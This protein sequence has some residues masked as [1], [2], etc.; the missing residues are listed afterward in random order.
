MRG[1]IPWLFFVICISGCT[2]PNNIGNDA[3]IHDSG[4]ITDSDTE[5]IQDSGSDADSDFD[6]NRDN[7]GDGYLAPEDCDDNDAS[8]NPEAEEICDGIDNNCNIQIDEGFDTD[9]DEY[10]SC[11]GDC[12]DSSAD[13]HPEALEYCNGTDNDCDGIIDNDCICHC[14]G[15]GCICVPG[16][17]RYCDTPEF[18]LWGRQ[19]CIDDGHR[20]G[21]CGEIPIPSVCSHTESWYSPAGVECCV[22]SGLCCQDM[23]D[24]DGDG[25]SWDSVGSCNAISCE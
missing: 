23:W 5:N 9:A 15:G 24:Y 6:S 14:P 7:D 16:S 19:T 2:D 17:E 18:S 13:I 12:N 4:F 10:T 20:W 22:E 3:D 25:E 21:S 8:I 1:K 11:G